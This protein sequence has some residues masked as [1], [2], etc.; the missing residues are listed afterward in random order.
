MNSLLTG[1]EDVNVDILSLL[2]LNE[3]IQCY[4]NQLLLN[5]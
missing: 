3:L 5:F 4:Y 2:T 1:N